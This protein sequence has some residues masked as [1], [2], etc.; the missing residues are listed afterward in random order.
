VCLSFLALFNCH[1]WNIETHTLSPDVVFHVSI[2][3]SISTLVSL[4]L[5]SSLVFMSRCVSCFL[6]LVRVAYSFLLLKVGHYYWAYF[7]CC[8]LT[9]LHVKGVVSFLHESS[10]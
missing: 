8:L 3:A 7:A 1:S 9:Y 2:L 5:A 6:S 10:G 4:G